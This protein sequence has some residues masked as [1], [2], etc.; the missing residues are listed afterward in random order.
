[1]LKNHSAGV[2]MPIDTVAPCLSQRIGQRRSSPLLSCAPV[3]P[4]PVDTF[5]SEPLGETVSDLKRWKQALKAFRP[6]T[7][8]QRDSRAGEGFTEK[9]K[10]KLTPQKLAAMSREQLTSVNLETLSDLHLQFGRELFDETNLYG[11]RHYGSKNEQR[12]AYTE[13]LGRIISIHGNNPVGQEAAYLMSDYL[14]RLARVET[15]AVVKNGPSVQACEQ[16]YGFKGGDTL[17]GFLASH[18][19]AVPGSDEILKTLRDT[20][21]NTVGCHRRALKEGATEEERRRIALSA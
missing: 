4:T 16:K 18:P 1:M 7:A 10:S 13:T 15:K 19:A 5:V 8:P 17:F 2:Q 14:G 9:E 20:K 12:A 6:Q 11:D 3:Q 21:L